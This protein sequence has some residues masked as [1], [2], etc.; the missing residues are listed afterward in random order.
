MALGRDYRISIDLTAYEHRYMR[1]V[2][3]DAVLDLPVI[4]FSV[5]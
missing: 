3:N 1:R 2:P 4:P 5:G